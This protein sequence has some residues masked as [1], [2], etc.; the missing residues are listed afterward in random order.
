M[1]DNVH[2]NIKNNSN[3]SNQQ[4]RY[5]HKS[6]Q[7]HVLDCSGLFVMSALTDGHVHVTATPTDDGEGQE[8]QRKQ[9]VSA[10]LFLL[11]YYC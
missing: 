7:T 11:H 8:N 9:D 5:M 4:Q 6:L 3:D 2:N 1:E 10:F